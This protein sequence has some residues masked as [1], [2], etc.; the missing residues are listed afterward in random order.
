MMS[1]SHEDYTRQFRR[2]QRAFHEHQIRAY[3][4]SLARYL[5]EHEVVQRIDFEFDFE[6]FFGGSDPVENPQAAWVLNER[7]LHPLIAQLARIAWER[8][9]LGRAVNAGLHR[10][11]FIETSE[12]ERLGLSA[13]DNALDY[14]IA[15]RQG[16]AGF[17]PP[18]EVGDRLL[19]VLSA[20][21]P[22]DS[23]AETT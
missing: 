16:E 17:V 12:P 20:L 3:A 7:G 10:I 5:H 8:D 4:R 13:A 15:L 11:R 22:R 9:D 18:R 6:G 21:Q 23:G 1:T 14:R 2:A 19:E